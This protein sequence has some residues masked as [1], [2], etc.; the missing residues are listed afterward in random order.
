MIFR[1]SQLILSI[2]LAAIALRLGSG[3][4]AGLSYLILA[5][6]AMY[7]RPQAIQALALSW[8]FTMLSPGIAPSPTAAS[9]GRYAVIAAVALSV[10]LRGYSSVFSMPFLMSGLLGTYLIFHSLFFS[11]VP[12][13]SLLKAISWTVV[14]MTLLAAWGRIKEDERTAI[15]RK[16]FGGLLAITLVSLPFA[17]SPLGYLA[18]QTGFQGMLN[19]PQAFGPTV[20]FLGGWLAGRLLASPKPKWH[21]AALLLLCIMLI[22]MSEA[23]VAGFAMVLGVVAAALTSSQLSGIPV[24]RLL[25]GLKSNRLLGFSL[26]VAVGL[27]L[28]ATAVSGRLEK[29]LTKRSDATSLLEAAEASRGGLVDAMVKNIEKNPLTG[30]G[31]GVASNPSEMVIERDP[32]FNLPTGAAIEKGVLPIAV[33][34]EIGIPGAVLVLAWLWVFIRRAASSGIFA[35]SV[36]AIIILANFGEATLFSPGGM[37]LLSLILLTWAATGKRFNPERRDN[38]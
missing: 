32:I 30:I 10:L 29:Y 21:E 16:I 6:Y 9:V 7:G 38:A 13:I 23:R 33:V 36:L 17:L 31:F 37:G 5:V 34:E 35:L 19:Q 2:P 12:D 27:T 28:G 4:T 3:L 25:P 1:H 15:E 8:L 11:V 18:N 14:T 20:A 24:K 26:I 22:L